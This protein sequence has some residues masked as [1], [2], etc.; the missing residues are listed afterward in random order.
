ML[1]TC[2]CYIVDTWIWLYLPFSEVMKSV[3]G[4]LDCP[5]AIDYTIC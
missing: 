1:L 3:T 2:E 5:S 4:K